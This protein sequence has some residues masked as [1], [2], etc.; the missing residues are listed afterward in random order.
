MADV[1]VHLAVRHHLERL[2]NVVGRDVELG[3]PIV[4]PI[5][6]GGRGFAEHRLLEADEE[7]PVVLPVTDLP[8]PQ[9]LVLPCAHVG[10]KTRLGVFWHIEVARHQFGHQPEIGQPLNI[11]VTAQRI[12]AAARNSD[13][14]EELLDHRH[15]AD[16]LAA[17]AVLRPA[18]REQ[19]GQCL[20]GCCGGGEQLA[21]LQKLSARCAANALD[22]FR[23]I[24]VNVFAQ[25]VD[26]ATRVREGIVD[27]GVA[28]LIELVV[29]ARF[30]V[31]AICRVVAGEKPVLEAKS[32]F[33]DEGRI[34]KGSNVFA[35]ECIFL[36]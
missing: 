8:G 31:L 12:H 16:V 34:G 17:D 32:F 15:S 36:Q 19:A 28:L 13:V 26:D 21:N 2:Q 22:H 11:G 29:P 30:V 20:V 18:K 23:R 5:V 9:R 27:L 14:A 4:G 1:T 24:A 25:Q 10:F 35:L 6:F 7:F 3:Q 33:Y